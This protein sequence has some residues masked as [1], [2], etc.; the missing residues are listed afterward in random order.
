VPT[1]FNKKGS[2]SF[3]FSFQG[4]FGHGQIND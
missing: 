1:S 4:A 3:L 2:V